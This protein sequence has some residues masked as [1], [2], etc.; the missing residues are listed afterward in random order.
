[1]NRLNHAEYRRALAGLEGITLLDAGDAE[2]WNAQYVVL[3]VHPD[4]AAL[5]RD[6]LL[7]VLRREGIRAR[8]YFWPGVHRQKPYRAAAA[9]LPETERIAERLLCLPTGTA[10][11]PEDIEAIAG[12]VGLAF[13]GA[14]EVRRQISG[15][16]SRAG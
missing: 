2:P 13:A 11:G 4:R 3:L 7:A 14:A 5:G 9:N 10:V 1:V 15:G 6:E 12:I 8:R 16:T